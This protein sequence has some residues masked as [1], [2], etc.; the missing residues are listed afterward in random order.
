MNCLASFP[1]LSIPGN[2]LRCPSGD[3][4]GQASKENKSESMIHFS[5]LN[6]LQD[7]FQSRQ[8]HRPKRKLLKDKPNSSGNYTNNNK[9]NVMELFR[10]A[11]GSDAWEKLVHA[12]ADKRQNLVAESPEVEKG[13]DSDPEDLIDIRNFILNL[14]GCSVMEAASIFLESRLTHKQV[15]EVGEVKALAYFY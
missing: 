5:V 9:Q 12:T 10:N 3:P 6:Y 7:L 11:L 4:L 1:C 15:L 13:P 14:R 8:S 2:R